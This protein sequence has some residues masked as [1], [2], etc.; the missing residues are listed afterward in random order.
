MADLLADTDLP[1]TT[2]GQ[3]FDGEFLDRR[4][5]GKEIA[6]PLDAL[7]LALARKRGSLALEEAVMGDV[8]RRIVFP[9]QDALS[10]IGS[11]FMPQADSPEPA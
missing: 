10:R 5:R 8:R 11:R 3:G 9:E 7:L 1:W 2:L 4:H 6:D